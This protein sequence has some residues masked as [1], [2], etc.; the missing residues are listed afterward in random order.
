MSLTHCFT[1]STCKAEGVP[2]VICAQRRKA[3]KRCYRNASDYYIGAY[4]VSENVHVAK[5]SASLARY[6][7]AIRLRAESLHLAHIGL[8]QHRHQ[9]LAANATQGF[10]W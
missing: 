1:G 4:A 6:H 2:I 10:N 8:R 3:K 9:E 5:H 7:V